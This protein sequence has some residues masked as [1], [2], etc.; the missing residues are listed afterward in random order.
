MARISKA[1]RRWLRGWVG[2]AIAAGANTISTGLSV[3][4]I[5]PAQF[6]FDA[7]LHNLLKAV[8]VGAL[9][10]AAVGAGLFLSKSPLPSEDDDDASMQPG[11]VL[12]PRGR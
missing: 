9:I 10:Q 3:I 8:S 4:V 12:P 6:N 7:G 5:D 1:M 11:R 2:A